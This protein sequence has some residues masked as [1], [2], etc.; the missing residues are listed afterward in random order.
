M[1]PEVF[2]ACAVT[3]AQACKKGDFDLSSSFIAPIFA[4][5][6]LLQAECEA[7][8]K[9]SPVSLNSLKLPVTRAGVVS[10]QM[11]DITLRKCF[12]TVDS[13]EEAQEKICIFY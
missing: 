4:N 12:S 1:Y 2:R 3:R 11:V 13:L 9:S 5:D 10:A 8:E 6:V 7:V